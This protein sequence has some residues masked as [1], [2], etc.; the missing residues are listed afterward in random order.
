MSAKE[1]S[2]SSSNPPDEKYYN[3]LLQAYLYSYLKKSILLN[4]QQLNSC[5]DYYVIDKNWIDELKKYIRFDEILQK[6]KEKK[7]IY[8]ID[9]DER[10]K[11]IIEKIFKKKK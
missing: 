8:I 3:N 7:V 2:S 9:E 5:E 6:L 4:S 11:P 10:I 1:N